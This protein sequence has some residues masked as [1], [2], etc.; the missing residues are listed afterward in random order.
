MISLGFISSADLYVSDEVT[1]LVLV[2]CRVTR[3]LIL[4]SGAT[5]IGVV[6]RSLCAC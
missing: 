2:G 1:C 6:V 4:I 5:S 3:K